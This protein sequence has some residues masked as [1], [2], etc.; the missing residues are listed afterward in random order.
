MDY[1]FYAYRLIMLNLGAIFYIEI[2]IRV[3][4]QC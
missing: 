2:L 4:P 1:L 3:Q